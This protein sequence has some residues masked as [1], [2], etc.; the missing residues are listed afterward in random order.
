MDDTKAR[1]IKR[2]YG[3]ELMKIAGVNGVSL[4]VDPDGKHL[5]V[6]LVGQ[7]FDLDQLPPLTAQVEAEGM[8]IK[9]E[10]TGEFIKS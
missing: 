5:M 8:R 7:G 3:S 4:Q 9:V 1:A 10:R 2:R 6:L